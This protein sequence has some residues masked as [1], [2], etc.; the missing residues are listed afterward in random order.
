M[1]LHFRRPQAMFLITAHCSI[2]T[3]GLIT[4][5]CSIVTEIRVSTS[6][7]IFR[8]V[9]HLTRRLKSGFKTSIR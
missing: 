6:R 2:V 5:H 1:R 4:A 8:L 9:E 7:L 3:V